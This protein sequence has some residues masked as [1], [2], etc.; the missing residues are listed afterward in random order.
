MEHISNLKELGNFWTL[1]IQLSKDR[2]NMAKLNTLLKTLDI[3]STIFHQSSEKKKF[4]L[5]KNWA[6]VEFLPINKLQTWIN[7][8]NSVKKNSLTTRLSKILKAL[9]TGKEKDLLPFWTES[10][11]EISQKL[12]LPTKSNY[13]NIYFTNIES[14]S[15]FSMK[16]LNLN[17]QNLQTTSDQLLQSYPIDT[18]EKKNRVIRSRKI[19]LFLNNQQKQIFKKWMGTSRYLYNKSIEIINNKQY[20]GQNNLRT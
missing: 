11:R 4:L 16:K 5:V 10:S 17:N 18:M 2:I 6:M 3:N 19:R 12:W 14:H 13:D 8:L 15:W 20:P 9:L 7:K 1:V